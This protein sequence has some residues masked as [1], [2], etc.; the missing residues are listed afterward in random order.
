MSESLSFRLIAHFWL[1]F[2]IQCKQDEIPYREV[3]K[4]KVRVS[5]RKWDKGLSRW[6]VYFSF[7]FQA[8]APRGL[9]FAQATR[10]ARISRAFA[11]DKSKFNFFY[12]FL[13][14]ALV[15]QLGSFAEKCGK[16]NKDPQMYRPKIF[17][18]WRFIQSCRTPSRFN[19]LPCSLGR[20]TDC[21]LYT[22]DAADE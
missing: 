4:Q 19:S 10:Y 6:K 2:K 9:V 15:W 13:L 20:N 1:R 11:F 5:I 21:L 12:T 17:S 7:K 18:V 14:V 22:S 3:G 8:L 16:A